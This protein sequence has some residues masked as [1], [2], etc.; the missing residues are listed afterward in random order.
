[1]LL[2]LPTACSDRATPSDDEFMQACLS[3]SNMG[4]ALCECIAGKA[5]AV[6][7]DDGFAFLV[8]SLDDDQKA[9]D[10]L[11]SKMPMDE[12]MQAGMFM[13][14]APADCASEQ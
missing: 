6:L 9:A 10:E 12:I 11:R 5:R 2:F 13:T 3:T 7:S 4:E 8:A 1:M 14:S